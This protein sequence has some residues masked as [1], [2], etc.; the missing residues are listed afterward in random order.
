MSVFAAGGQYLVLA[1][2]AEEL[3]AVPDQTDPARTGIAIVEGGTERQLDDRLITGGSV[4]GLLR[5]QNHDLREA[6]ALIGRL[7]AAVAGA[8]NR[9]QQ[10]GVNLYQPFNTVPAEPFFRVGDPRAVPAQSNQR[11][12]N[13]LFVSSVA[14]TINDPAALQASEYRFRRDPGGVP[15]LFELTRLSDGLVR[16]VV[17]GD[18]VDGF[19]IDVGVPEPALTDSFRLQP[20]SGAAAGMRL[21]L[22]DVRDIAAASALV[23]TAV[24]AA[25][26]TVGVDA[27]RML[28]PPPFPADRIRITFTTDTGDYTWERIDAGTNNVL[29]SGNGVWQAGGPIPAPPV[30]LNGFELTLLGVPRTGDL[31]RID[32]ADAN[33]F[34]QNNGNALALAELRD[35]A[36]VGGTTVTEAYAGAI[37]NVGVRVQGAKSTA[38]ISGAMAE[39]AERARS[40]VSG[41][42]L[43]EEAARLIQYQQSYQAAAKVLQVA[44]TVFDLLLETAGR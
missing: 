7:A 9:Q 40:A 10:L 44:Q 41:V 17:S 2:R 22:D 29:D 34:S 26:G 30:D 38:Q 1:T 13:G 27:L 36:I 6:G 35:A 37:A 42:N 14:L 20:V 8:V 21:L 19:T 32:P 28:S 43:D 25:T 15:G 16:T 4:A 24:P 33:N 23:A 12:P 3:R 18:Q 5:F 11:D 39:Q 31:I